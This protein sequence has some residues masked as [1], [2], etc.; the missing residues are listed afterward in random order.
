[1]LGGVDSGGVFDIELFLLFLA[2]IFH[3]GLVCR[4][5]C[6]LLVLRLFLLLDDLLELFIGFWFVVV[7]RGVFDSLFKLYAFCCQ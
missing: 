6:L 2:L 1:V 3:F 5:A 4:F 7:L